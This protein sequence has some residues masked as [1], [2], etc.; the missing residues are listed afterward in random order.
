MIRRI[1][2]IQV[3][4]VLRVAIVPQSIETYPMVYG[5]GSGQPESHREWLRAHQLGVRSLFQKSGS[6][7]ASNRERG[8]L[9]PIHSRYKVG[10]SSRSR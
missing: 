8:A 9:N 5:F 7:P 1:K 10:G 6:N 2:N 3:L 4:Y